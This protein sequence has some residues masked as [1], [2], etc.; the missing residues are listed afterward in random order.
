MGNEYG[1]GGEKLDEGKQGG[2]RDIA[3]TGP[4]PGAKNVTSNGRRPKFL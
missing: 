2:E 4:R 3:V 1:K